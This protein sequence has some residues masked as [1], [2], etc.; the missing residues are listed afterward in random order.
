MA[1][2]DWKAELGPL[3]TN[4]GPWERPQSVT[5]SGRYAEI[6][7]LDLSTQADELWEQMNLADPDQ[8]QWKYLAG[9][10]PF[11]TQQ[12]W[13]DT[14]TSWAAANDN[15]TFAVRDL[16]TGKLTGQFSL[17][18]IRPSVGS[19]EVGF[20]RFPPQMQGSRA[21]T[22]AQYSLMHYILETLGYRR[23]EWKCDASNQPSMVTAKR[24]GFTFEGTFRNDLVVHGRNRDT[25]W[26]SI[27]DGEWPAIRAGFQAWL[28][29]NNFDEQGRQRA[30]LLDLIESERNG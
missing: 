13:V 18:R 25:A 22:E 2:G 1:L 29:P 27:T 5:L 20:V 16:S 10:G 24:L 15:E 6:V 11:K 9:M 4:A 30:R 28:G 17:L 26:W 19:A 8:R 7:A 21:S 12:Q 23:W 14:W 3:I